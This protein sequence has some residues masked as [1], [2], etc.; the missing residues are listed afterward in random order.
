MFATAA[1]TRIDSR[2]QKDHN[3]FEEKQP[4]LQSRRLAA[5]FA[6][7]RPDPA[8]ARFAASHGASPWTAVL[9]DFR[10]VLG[11]PA[12]QSAMSRSC[13]HKKKWPTL[14]AAI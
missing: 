13:W 9:S 6:R 3:G 7:F 8:A 11:I 10:H 2:C 5:R 12:Q 14:N 1:A 4:E